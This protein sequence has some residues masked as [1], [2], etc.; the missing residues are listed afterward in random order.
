MAHT[1]Q[2]MPDSDLGFQVTVLK[3]TQVVPSSLGS[4]YQTQHIQC[5]VERE[6]ERER[7]GGRKRQTEREQERESETD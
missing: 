5:A 4:G 1:R 6:R 3:K 2:P 7:G